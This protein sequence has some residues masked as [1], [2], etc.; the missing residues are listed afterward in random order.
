MKYPFFSAII[1]LAVVFPLWPQNTIDITLPSNTGPSLVPGSEELPRSFRKL[2]LGMSLDDLKKALTDD[3]LFEFR[4]D[5]DVSFLP[6]K[7][8]NLVETAGLSFIRRAFFQL[9]EKA[10]FIMAFTLDSRRIDHYSVFTSLVKK[11]GEPAS[12]NPRE[13]V[14]ENDTT[15]ISLERPLTVKYID[16]TVFKAIIDEAKTVESTEVFRRQGF[17]NDF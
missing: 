17:L 1:F 5:P 6:M 14:W 10:V 3:E 9:R 12:L 4:G 2:Q 8:E 11:Y 13:A 7:E 15:R 16:M